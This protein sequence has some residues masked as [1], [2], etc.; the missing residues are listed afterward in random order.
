MRAVRD[1][2]KRFSR[3][4]IETLSKKYKYIKMSQCEWD[5]WLLE[6]NESR[7]RSGKSCYGKIPILTFLDSLLLQ[8]IKCCCIVIFQ[9]KME[10]DKSSDDV[11]TSI[12]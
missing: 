4:S 1:F 7:L 10:Y 9:T 12:L 5:E 3:N 11:V 2:I 6:Y 8:K